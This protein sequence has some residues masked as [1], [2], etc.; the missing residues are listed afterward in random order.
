MQSKA[1]AYLKKSSNTSNISSLFEFL[2]DRD[3]VF[4]DKVARA[5]L[6]SGFDVT[7]WQSCRRLGDK[8]LVSS[9]GVE[10][11]ID[12]PRGDTQELRG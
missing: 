9:F 10:L 3:V 4:V 12:R 11:P 8:G 1:R 6:L 2:A 5:G 7:K